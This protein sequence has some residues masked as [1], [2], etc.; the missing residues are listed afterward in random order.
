MTF[1]PTSTVHHKLASAFPRRTPSTADSAPPALREALRSMRGGAFRSLRLR[2]HLNDG[3]VK[4]N[5]YLRRFALPQAV[6]ELSLSRRLISDSGLSSAGSEDEGDARAGGEV[7]YKTFAALVNACEKEGWTIDVQVATQVSVNLAYTTTHHLAKMSFG[8]PQLR[9]G[10]G[11]AGGS[12]V[13]PGHVPAGEAA[14]G[15]GRGH[16]SAQATRQGG[17]HAVAG[18]PLLRTVER[19]LN[20]KG[21]LRRA[22]CACCHE[23]HAS[24]SR[25]YEPR[26]HK[27]RFPTA[28]FGSA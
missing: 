25:T 11:L 18:F 7:A 17:A 22:A 23:R 6:R 1:T 26:F 20:L 9:V 3:D 16:L 27:R 10:Y 5:G 28:T 19:A 2:R 15:L 24:R 8:E 12:R 4:G 14:T 21:F 13:A